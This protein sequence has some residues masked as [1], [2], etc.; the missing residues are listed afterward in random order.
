[1]TRF[2]D[3]IF[4]FVLCSLHVWWGED[5]LDAQGEIDRAIVAERVFGD[6]YCLMPNA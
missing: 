6:G 5:I 4:H 2:S 1:M 3:P